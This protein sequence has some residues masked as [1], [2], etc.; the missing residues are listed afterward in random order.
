[1]LAHRLP[2]Y[3]RPSVTED[4]GDKPRWVR[5]ANGGVR[6]PQKTI[7]TA[8]Q[9]AQEMLLSVDDAVGAIGSALER[10][11]RLDNTLLFY[12]SD[13][14]EFRGEHHLLGKSAP[15]KMATMVP[16]VVRYSGRLPAGRTWDRLALNIDIAATVADAT[17]TPM[18]TDGLSLLG[19]VQRSGTVLEAR[20]GTR[21]DAQE[22][23]PAYSG[24]RTKTMMFAHYADG[25]EELY[26]YGSDPDELTNRAYQRAYLK[27]VLTMRAE[28][29][30]A[31]VPAPPGVG[32]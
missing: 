18:V 9:R 21:A 12:I 20:A 25:E 2:S 10:A 24:W 4:V 6:I 11:G 17:D 30:S 16:F 28:A 13:N 5:Q 3:H 14:G 7:D 22:G 27:S 15:Y 31:C 26:D 23:R 29:R 8:D 19:R 32:W 1:V